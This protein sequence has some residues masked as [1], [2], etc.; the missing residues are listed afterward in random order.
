MKHAGRVAVGSVHPS[1]G[2]V[3]VEA[4]P[5]RGTLLPRPGRYEL[6]VF[7]DG[8]REA[9]VPLDAVLRSD[10]EAFSRGDRSEN[11]PQSARPDA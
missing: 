2:A 9:E 5:M 1:L 11:P 4:F 10:L 8:H 7:V 3:H 6:V